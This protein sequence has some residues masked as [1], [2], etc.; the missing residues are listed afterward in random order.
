MAHCGFRGVLIPVAIGI[1]L[2]V[3]CVGTGS[4]SSQ[5]P[6]PPPSSSS[7]KAPAPPPSSSGSK[8]PAPPSS[9]SGSKAPAPASP[10]TGLDR[11]GGY[12]DLAVKGAA[13]GFFRIDKV[14]ARW[15]LVTPDNH[16]FWALSVYGVNTG[17]G[18]PAYVEAVKKKYDSPGWMPW[19][20]FVRQASLRL[21][22]WG[23]NTLGEY[24]TNYAL[25]IPSYG[26]RN[27]NPVPMPFISI[28]NPSYWAKRY[29]AVKNIQLGVDPAVTPG[30]WRVEG[31]PD[32]FDP[33]YQAALPG[34]AA[35]KNIFNV[36]PLASTPWHI[37]T[38]TDDGDD[39]FGFGPVNTHN[40]LG[41]IAAAT[42]PSQARNDKRGKSNPQPTV[43]KDTKVYTKYALRD[44]LRTRYSSIEKLNAAWGSKYTTWDSDGGWPNGKGFLDESGRSPWLGKDFRQLKDSAPKVRTDLNDFV[45][46][47]ADHY[48]KIVS[49]AL[50]DAQPH[51]LVIAPVNALGHPKI[52]EAAGR[53][54]DFVQVGGSLKVED[55]RRVYSLVRKPMLIWT[56][57]M[58]QVDSP[59]G[60][61][62]KGWA[63]LDFPTQEE[64]GAAYE[65]FIQN[66]L[67]FQADDGTYPI[68]GIDWWAWTD[69][70]VGGEG[71]NFGLVT[72]RDNAYDGK[73][74]VIA[75]GQDPWGHPTGGEKGNY[76]DFLSRVTRTN[77]SIGQ[78]LRKELS[79]GR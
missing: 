53:Y 41:W 67:D 35:R 37:G 42:A 30:L 76:G 52:L 50:R 47:L 48:F 7:S 74:A 70:T 58:S 49:T 34:F 71:N 14:G 69:K 21:K 26:G 44:F 39:L 19:G 72:N 77:A 54:A 32:V 27:V 79:A 57:Y 25:P 51:H 33:A 40:N 6:A 18:G 55:F 62:K 75:A 46:V 64:R 2:V 11:Y 9:S 3:G 31:F 68:I 16:V 12:A 45:G 23:F 36:V 4:S 78:T 17:D 59:L 15:V 24:T 56:T 8:A 1:G 63:G 13:S 29:A 60:N 20:L 61:N 38:T 66:I 5:A 10:S 22:S 65:K 73:E 43:Y 28:I